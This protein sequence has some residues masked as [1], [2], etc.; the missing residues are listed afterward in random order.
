[1]ELRQSFQA[2]WGKRHGH[3]EIATGGRK[4]VLSLRYGD[5]SGAAT[6]ANRLAD[7]LNQYCEDL[8]RKVQQ[9]MYSVE[10][11]MSSALSNADYYVNQ[12]ITQL[13]NREDSARTLSGKIQELVDTAK[14]VDEDVERMIQDNQESFFQKNPELKAPWYKQAWTTFIC[15]MKNVPV[16]GWLIQ[17][18]EDALNAIDALGREIKHWWKCGGGKELIMNCLDIVIKIG[19]AVAAVLTAV[20]AVV[21]LATATVITGGAI[22]FAVAA[23]VTAVIAA[24]NAVTNIVTSVQAITASQGGDPAMA[25]IYGERDTL[26]QVLR[27]HNFHNRELNRAS[28]TAASAIE[29]TDTIAG[30][31]TLVHSIGKIA[32]SFLSKNGVGFAFK[33]LARGSDGKPIKK[34][35]LKSIWKGTKALV[36]NQKLT[37]STSTG[38]RTTLFTNIKQSFN[39]Q[40]TLFKMA[41]RDPGNWFRTRQTGDMGFFRNMMEKMRHSFSQFKNTAFQFRQGDMQYNL[42]K[43]SNLVSVANDGLEFTKDFLEGLDQTD[44]KGLARRALEKFSQDK[45]FGNDF[46]D[47]MNKTG[48]GGVIVDFDKS[49]FLKDFTGMGDGIYQNIRDIGKSAKLAAPPFGEF[50]PYFEYVRGEED[51]Q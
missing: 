41:V 38:L 46:F 27:E 31:I 22:L 50:F 51:E 24:V 2:R 37:T 15:D 32:G 29:I 36:L 45:L 49:G 48:L 47:L 10:G 33:E 4:V 1:M 9:K 42:D 30:V 7:E 25:K 17:G 21:A 3:I 39:Y 13:R 5:L 43:I 18:G 23:C 14:R 16:L 26:A 35:T 40:V 11:G 8:S 20:A 19:A 28:Y 44:N 12:K 34:V 6:E